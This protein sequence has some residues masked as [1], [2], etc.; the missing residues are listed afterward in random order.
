MGN[1]RST[2]EIG[3]EKEDLAISFLLNNQCRIIERNFYMRGG[4]IDIVAKENHSILF[5]EVKYRSSNKC[6]G[7]YYS[8]SQKKQIRIA[9]TALYYMKKRNIP[10]ECSIRFDVIL[11]H[12]CSN[13]EQEITWI[14]NAFEFP[15]T[16]GF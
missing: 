5:I 2:R 1:Q 9:K 4:E 6:G 14:K 15:A 12:D 7:A 8:V 10:L 16:L 13:N 11:I 3:K